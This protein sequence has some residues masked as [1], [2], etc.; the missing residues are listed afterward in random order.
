[1]MARTED[2]NAIL[3]EG[4][5]Q[6]RFRVLWRQYR[7]NRN[8]IVGSIV[9]S[10]IA[11]LA[12]FAP[13]LTPYHPSDD[14]DLSQTLLPPGSEGHPLGT[15]TNGRDLLSRMLFGA[16]ISLTVGLVVQA[17]A[18]TIGTTVGLL[19]GYLGGRVDE[20]FSGVINIIYSFPS[21]LFAIA[22]MSV[23]GPGLYNIFFALGF[24]GWATVARLV[25][26]EVL[27]AKSRDFIEAA[28]A[29]GATPVR[30]MLRHLLPNCLGPIVV[31]GTLGV[32]GAIMS[33]ATLSFLGLGIQPPAP[34]WGSMLSRGREYI[35]IAPH[36]TI[37]P[38]I[39]IFITVLGLNLLGDG[40][41]DIL[42]PRLKE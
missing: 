13:V 12:I 19:A 42:D 40:L 28:R 38:G 10:A 3:V 33:E 25:R 37:T 14:F 20:V 24:I 18:V 8:A 23:L 21:L 22:T 2:Q 17:I 35:W 30:V 26:G 6:D 41:R 29:S 31:V 1:M 7:K 15:D 11:L 5:R 34:S 39:A 9:V 4:P 36:L 16:R 32:A 27:S